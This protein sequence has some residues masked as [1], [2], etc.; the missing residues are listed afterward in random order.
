MSEQ[1]DQA[2][3]EGG[4]RRLL[5]CTAPRILAMD[6]RACPGVRSVR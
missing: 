3:L 1:T 4:Y 5:A 6:G 2:R